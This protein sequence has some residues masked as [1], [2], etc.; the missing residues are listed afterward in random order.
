MALQ[1]SKGNTYPYDYY[2]TDSSNPVTISVTLD[3]TGGTTNT[4]TVTAYLVAYQWKYTTIS[5]G[6]QSETAG[7]DWKISLDNSTWLDTV[8]PAEMNAL[9]TTEANTTIKT[10]IYFRAVVNNDSTVATGIYTACQVKITSTESP[11]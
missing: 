8:T 4:G 6:T 10:P 7:I 3:N 9:A 5:V 2:S 1:L 11:E